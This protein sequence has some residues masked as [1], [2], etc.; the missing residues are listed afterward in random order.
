[1]VRNI[2]F[3]LAQT[4]GLPKINLS[5][6]TLQYH[7]LD[8]DL[9]FFFACLNELLHD[10]SADLKTEHSLSISSP[11]KNSARSW[12]EEIIVSDSKAYRFIFALALF[13]ELTAR[14]RPQEHIF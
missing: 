9:L 1:L 11:R 6:S 8:E 14:F 13:L 3:S 12:C 7:A 2:S 5:R 10:G 4:Q